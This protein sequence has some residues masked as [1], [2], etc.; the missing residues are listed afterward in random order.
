[1]AK[2]DGGGGT[3]RVF[4]LDDHEMIRRGVRD[5]L[6][7]ED[8]IEVV[9]ESATGESAIVRVPLLDV[10]VAILDVR[11]AEGDGI[12]VCREIRSASPE[13]ACLMLTGHSDDEAMLAAIMAGA[14]GYV[15]KL[16]VGE[17]LV[18][19]VRAV[20]AGRSVLGPDAAQ[21][22]MARI[23]AQ[24]TATDPLAALSAHEK[25]VL[26]LIGEGLTNREIA[27]RLF[28]SEKTVKNYVSSLLAKL[29]MQRRSQVAALAARLGASA[30]DD[31]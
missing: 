15:T 17:E 6:N 10:D 7:A 11:L 2:A 23:R 30:V 4:I 28:L 27:A 3:I 5:C 24:A 26:E 13:T 9:G 31:E 1:M 8:G 19:A 20:A 21:R 16:G 14:V 22:V 25:R 12:Q 18:E 29:G